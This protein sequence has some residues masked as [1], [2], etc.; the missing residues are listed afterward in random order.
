[1]SR[2]PPKMEQLA[3][4]KA[5]VYHVLPVVE[6]G[7]TYS[8]DEVRT[9]KPKTSE[10]FLLATDAQKNVKWKASVY[11]LIYNEILE[12]DVQDIFVVDLYVDGKHITV[13][14]EHQGTFRFDRDT[15][16]KQDKNNLTL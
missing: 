12:T 4:I 13:K 9:E 2:I 3:A 16:K 10:F 7:I 11:R 8:I 6:E 5:K 15:G 1:M 14:L